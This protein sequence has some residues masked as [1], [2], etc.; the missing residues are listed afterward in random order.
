MRKE[1]ALDDEDEENGLLPLLPAPLQEGVGSP[2]EVH[3]V[4]VHLHRGVIVV[5][6]VQSLTLRVVAEVTEIVDDSVTV[7]GS[8]IVV[9]S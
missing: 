9:D 7:V 5:V 8:I 1:R 6:A 3:V 4:L 2:D